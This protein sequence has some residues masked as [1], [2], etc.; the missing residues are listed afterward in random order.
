MADSDTWQRALAQVFATYATDGAGISE[1]KLVKHTVKAAGKMGLPGT[2]HA[3]TKQFHDYMAGAR[4]CR[5]S[6]AEHGTHSGVT[7]PLCAAAM[8]MS[9]RVSSTR[10]LRCA[11]CHCPPQLP[12]QHAGVV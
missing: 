1:D 6:K 2:K 11:L 9:S 3:R 10:L 5:A 8:L 7:R 4:C 12:H